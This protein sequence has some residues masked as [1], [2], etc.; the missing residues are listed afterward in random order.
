MMEVEVTPHDHYHIPSLVHIAFS[1]LIDQVNELLSSCDVK[2]L[3]EQCASIM[4]CEQNNIKL[5]SN[6]Q[7][8]KMSECCNALSLL[9]SLSRFLSWSNHSFLRMLLS[10]TL[11]EAQ[12]LLDEFDSRLDRKQSVTSYPIPLFSS[13]MIP[14]DTSSYTILAIRCHQEAYEPT[15]QDV[16]DIQSLITEVCDI[17][18][19]CLQLLATRNNL[20]V[21]YWTIPKCVVK[22]LKNLVPKHCEYLYSKGVLEV[23]IYPKVL[24][25]TCNDINIISLGR[26]V[27]VAEKVHSYMHASDK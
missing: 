20:A 15:L 27:F 4:A 21:I 18:Q 7:I 9:Q 23:L 6:Y 1:H 10:E 11:S 26:S 25:T 24:L 19:H 22:I 14:N 8:K 3:I 2:K 13:D 16:Y 12:Q 5:F 17:T